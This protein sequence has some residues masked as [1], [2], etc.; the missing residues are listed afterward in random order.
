MDETVVELAMSAD[1]VLMGMGGNGQQGFLEETAR[2]FSEACHTHAGIDQQIAVAPA[3]MPDVA[4][5]ERHDMRLPQQGD[6]VVDAA[7]VE[8]AIGNLHGHDGPVGM[9][10][11]GNAA[12]GRCCLSEGMVSG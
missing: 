12:G 3:D 4:A 11:R 9:N 1:M 8:P 5:H 7:D 10:L 2:G 6:I